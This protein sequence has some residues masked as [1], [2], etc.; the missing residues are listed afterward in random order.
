[1]KIPGISIRLEVLPGES[2]AKQIENAANYGFDAIAL[3]GRFKEKWMP[4]LREF[5]KD[6]PLPM[7]SVSLGFVHSLLSPSPEQRKACRDSLLEL[8][9]LCAEFGAGILNLPP[10]LIQDN[11]ERFPPEDVTRQD[12][13][14]IEQLPAL[15]DEAAKRKINLLIEPVNRSET[16]YLK[17]VGHATRICEAVD[18]PS[19]GLTSDFYHMQIEELDTPAALRV[20]A[21]WIRLVHTAEKNRVEPGAGQVDF[22][23]GFRALKDAGY[24]G[25]L[26]VECRKLSGPAE[27]VLP[28]SVTYLRNEWSEA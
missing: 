13:L 12:R 14:L 1:M 25:L 18:H 6:S 3:P 4:G 20:A 8:L 28:K 26:E 24:N 19:I 5:L 17:T 21:P 10:C 9:D 23:P 7:A 2:V 16:E 22:Q 15:G 11:P 27:E